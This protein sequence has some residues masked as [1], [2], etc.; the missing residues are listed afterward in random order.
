MQAKYNSS[1]SLHSPFSSYFSPITS[2][3]STSH[4]FPNFLHLI[5]FPTILF[6]FATVGSYVN[7][8]FL[9]V[10]NCFTPSGYSNL[11]TFRTDPQRLR[12]VI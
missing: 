3:F 6:V 5:P 9:P 1:C 10:T 7:L 8:I 2:H 11:S 4:I 12:S